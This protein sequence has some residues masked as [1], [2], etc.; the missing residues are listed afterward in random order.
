MLSTN[1]SKAP[2]WTSPACSTT[3]V[4]DPGRSRPRDTGRRVVG[5]PRRQHRQG[6]LRQARHS[7]GRDRWTCAAPRG[8]DAGTGT[9]GQPVAGDVPP[10]WRSTVSRPAARHVRFAVVAPVT[11]PTALPAGSPRR[12]TSQ[13]LAISSTAVCAGVTARSRQFWSHAVTNQSGECRRH[14]AA[15]DE[16]VEAT[17][18]KRREARLGRRGEQV[19]H[20]GGLARPVGE[21]NTECI[22]NLVHRSQR[23]YA[24]LAETG[25]PPRRMVVGSPQS[26]F[27]RPSLARW[28]SAHG[29]ASGG[30]PAATPC[31]RGSGL[32]EVAG[33]HAE[34]AAEV[35]SEVGL[36]DE[37]DL[38][39]DV[40]QRLAGEDPPRAD[41]SA[42]QARSG[43][44]GFRTQLR[45]A[46]QAG[47][48]CSQYCARRGHRHRL[49]EGGGRGRREALRRGRRRGG[50]RR[51]PVPPTV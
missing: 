34:E 42:G 40:R 22:D 44:G 12:S 39:G 25:Q 41:R 10:A 48:A 50:R 46:R 31:R 49:E 21:V 23:W 5:D 24:S 43:A 33:C 7:A 17:A 4:G 8:D 19:D 32:G 6:S 47:G 45:G 30:G 26:R 38:G 27:V 1:G 35:P 15:G 29:G 51:P 28:A 16:P 37:A 36:V 20:V 14:A 11:K 2:E 9:A 3:I 18:R 13:A